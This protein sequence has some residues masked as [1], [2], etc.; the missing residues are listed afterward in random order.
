VSLEVSA[1]PLLDTDFVVIPDWVAFADP[2]VYVD[3]PVEAP[4]VRT[5]AVVSRAASLPDDE[6]APQ[7]STPGPA[8]AMQIT[9]AVQASAPVVTT[10]TTPATQPPARIMV[11]GVTYAAVQA[12]AAPAQITVAPAPATAIRTA[13]PATMTQATGAPR[14]ATCDGMLP[15]GC[16]LAKRK[17]STPQ[18]SELRCTV[19]CD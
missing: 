13:A 12:P 1:A 2:V 5:T 16:Y 3:V 8:P 10:S 19:V 14:P 17:F 9:P 18:G 4:P 11:N 15:N 6:S 7:P